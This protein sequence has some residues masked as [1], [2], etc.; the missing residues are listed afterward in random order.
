MHEGTTKYAK[1]GIGK[2]KT[3]N[4]LQ[5]DGGV[6][7]SDDLKQAQVSFKQY[8]GKLWNKYVLDVN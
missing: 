8:A 5:P 4:A 3:G 2:I 6:I 7:T 1:R